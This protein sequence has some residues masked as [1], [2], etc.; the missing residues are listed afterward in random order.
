MSVK[1]PGS[2]D[3]LYWGILSYMLHE[4]GDK[5]DALLVKFIKK[6]ENIFCCS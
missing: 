4:H 2:G 1:G 6:V 3:A 5:S